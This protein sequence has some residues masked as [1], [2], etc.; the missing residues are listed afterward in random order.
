MP[1]RIDKNDQPRPVVDENLEP[2]LVDELADAV[3]HLARLDR[4][5]PRR[6]DLRVRPTGPGRL[7]HRVADDRHHLRRVEREPG[8]V[9]L[10]ER[11]PGSCRLEHCIADDRDR[12][13]RVQQEARGPVPARELGRTKEQQP[14]LLPRRQSHGRIV[15]TAGGPSL[16]ARNLNGHLDGEAPVNRS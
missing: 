15:A 4:R 16:T 3:H 2:D 8:G 14:L 7:E 1:E 9:D 11:P 6:L 13:R 12:L 5:Q 10:R